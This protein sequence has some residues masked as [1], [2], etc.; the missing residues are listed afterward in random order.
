[1]NEHPH[2]KDFMT[3]I[4]TASA[5]FLALTPVFLAIQQVHPAVISHVAL[6]A[7]YVVLALSFIFGLF[8]ISIA[9]E[10]FEKST[11]SRRLRAKLF[12]ILQT[13]FF[14][15]GSVALLI[16]TLFSN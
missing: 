9:V 1:M 13:G 7:L 2:D 6:V 10:W 4:I 16:P 3:A 12:L 8:A 5:V 14:A 11:A 15:L